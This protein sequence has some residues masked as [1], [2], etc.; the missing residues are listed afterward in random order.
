MSDPIRPVIAGYVEDSARLDRA[1]SVAIVGN[2]AYVAANAAFSVVDVSDPATPRI[3]GSVQ[4]RFLNGSRSVAV[5]GQYAYVAALSGV[6]LMVVDVSD[7]TLPTLA[8]ATFIQHGK[9]AISRS[10][11]AAAVA[12]DGDYAYVAAGVSIQVINISNRSKPQLVMLED[13]G[14]GRFEQIGTVLSNV[15]WGASSVVIVGKYAYVAAIVSHSLTIVDVSDP[16]HPRIVGSV[17]NSTQLRAAT[18]VAVAGSYAYITAYWGSALTVV[19][20]SDPASPRITGWAQ[21]SLLNGSTSVAIRGSYAYVTAYHGAHGYSLLTIVN[22][23]DPSNPIIA[24]TTTS[25]SDREG[26]LTL[27]ILARVGIILAIGCGCYGLQMCWAL[28]FSTLKLK[29]Q[30]NAEESKEQC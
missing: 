22:I 20:I 18:S 10:S 23:S 29:R 24:G 5:V 26:G 1:K 9:L 13:H 16:I 25:R 7:P 30:E 19:N 12:I 17:Q 2:Y 11:G 6:A 14:Q 15:L 8:G 4:D 3:I 21:D 27:V 28:T